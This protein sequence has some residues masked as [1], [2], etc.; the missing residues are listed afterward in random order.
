M[1]AVAPDLA[2]N[3]AIGH[4][5]SAAGRWIAPRQRAMVLDS[6]IHLL[7]GDLGPPGE[8]TGQNAQ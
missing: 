3:P 1:V 2:A 8:A 6:V 4:P 7:G 5:L